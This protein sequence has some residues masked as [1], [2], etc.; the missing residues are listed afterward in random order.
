MKRMQKAFLPVGAAQTLNELLYELGVLSG[1]KADI[2]FVVGFAAEL[3]SYSICNKLNCLGTTKSI[4][5]DAV[6][7]DIKTAILHYFAHIMQKRTA[8][9]S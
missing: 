4:L 9:R 3:C 1:L 7:C 6:C 2:V 8:T 5:K